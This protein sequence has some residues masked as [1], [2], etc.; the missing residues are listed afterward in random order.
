M[1]N[2]ETWLV[3][4]WYGEHIREILE[5]NSDFGADDLRIIV[6][7]IAINDQQLDGFV[8]D[9]ISHFLNAVDWEEL[10]KNLTPVEV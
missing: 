4:V 10:Y 1:F 9:A 3:N 7:D 2:T 8:A 5:E 6:E